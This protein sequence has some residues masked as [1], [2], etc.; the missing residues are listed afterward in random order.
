MTTNANLYNET[1]APDE[2][3]SMLVHATD[4]GGAWHHEKVFE[5]VTQSTLIQGQ[6]SGASMVL[7]IEDH[8]H[9]SCFAFADGLFWIKYASNSL[10]TWEDSTIV[11]AADIWTDQTSIAVDSKG[12]ASISYHESFVGIQMPVSQV[13]RVAENSDGAWKL[14]TL[15]DSFIS[16]WFVGSSITVEPDGGTHV[17]Y[18]ILDKW[19]YLVYAT[20][21]ALGPVLTNAFTLSAYLGVAAAA[22]VVVIA[23]TAIQY[24]RI[25][26]RREAERKE[27]EERFHLFER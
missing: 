18:S 12:H 7:D 22:I 11:K 25:Q 24:V 27:F 14:T 15:D 1:W 6:I 26:R 13:V 21:S 23:A 8:I 5:S 10:G 9:V 17:L 20:D 19:T 2:Y 4:S 3:H 16:G